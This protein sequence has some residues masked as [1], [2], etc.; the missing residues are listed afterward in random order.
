MRGLFDGLREGMS[1]E[2]TPKKFK[3][4]LDSMTA[5]S[6]KV[7]EAVPIQEAWTV[8]QI[9]TAL[10]RTSS[11]RVDM[12]TATGC[13]DTLKHA[14]LVKEIERGLFRQVVPRETV[15]DQ[16]AAAIHI[17]ASAPSVA[18]RTRAEAPLEA[19]PNFSGKIT[20]ADARE[21]KAA[22]PDPIFGTVGPAESFGDLAVKLRLK[23][24]DLTRMADLIDSLALEFEQRIEDNEKK[25]QR[26]NA[27]RALLTEA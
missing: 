20:L 7:F 5:I 2:M 4:T 10:G 11:T 16:I 23:A 14:G 26:F 25:L 9:V 21:P 24:A 8:N 18:E 19:H 6:G 12:K 15:A 13:L 3:L 1:P 17:P 22:E 27:L